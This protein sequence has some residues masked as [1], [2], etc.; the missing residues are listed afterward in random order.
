MKLLRSIK[1][2]VTQFFDKLQQGT[3]PIGFARKIGVGVGM[4]CRFYQSISY[5]SEPYLI[6]IGDHVTI[7]R[8][9]A[10][11]THDGG[12]WIL[13]H[14]HPKMDVFGTITIGNNVFVGREAMLMPGV[15]IGDN[16]VIGVRALVT[17]D[18]PPNSIAVGMPAKVIG[19]I[20]DYE[21]K[22]LPRSLNTKDF[23]PKEKKAF[24]KKHFNLK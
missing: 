13:R 22:M 9:V 1:M 6:S 5:G 23:T 2:I 17:R 15:T 14:K 11:I 20:D 3:D 12:A 10:F 21:K 16:C 19:T 7:T 18:I 8:G 24:L 4:N